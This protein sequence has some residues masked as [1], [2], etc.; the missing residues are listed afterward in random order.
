[1]IENLLIQK[2]NENDTKL[3]PEYWK[4]AYKKP[5]PRISWNMKGNYKSCNPN[6]RKCSL[7]LHEKLEIVDDPEE[8]LLG[9]EWF[10]QSRL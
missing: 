5:H 7:C 3:S 9:S 1:M 8:I 10:S 4:L 6:S 2:K